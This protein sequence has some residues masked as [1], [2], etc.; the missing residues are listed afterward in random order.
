RR[1]E[2]RHL[3]KHLLFPWG[4]LRRADSIFRRKLIGRLVPCDRFQGHFRFEVCAVSF[5]LLHDELLATFSIPL[6]YLI[7]LSSFWGILYPSVYPGIRS[8]CCKSHSQR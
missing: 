1:E 4:N 3:V 6:F 7:L 5:P 2:M 8:L